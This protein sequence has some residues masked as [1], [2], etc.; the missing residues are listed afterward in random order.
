MSEDDQIQTY[1]AEPIVV[2]AKAEEAEEFDEIDAEGLGSFVEELDDD[3]LV[4]LFEALVKV[5]ALE[6]GAH[7][8]KFTEKERT[9]LGKAQSAARLAGL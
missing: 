8:W 2:E 3:E 5:D 9:I 1:N 4:S 7:G 6:R